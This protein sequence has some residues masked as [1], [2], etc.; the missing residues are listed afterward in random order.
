MLGMS[1]KLAKKKVAQPIRTTTLHGAVLPQTHLAGSHLV[2]KCPLRGQHLR[3]LIMT[4]HKRPNLKIIDLADSSESSD[5]MDLEPEWASAKVRVALAGPSAKAPL[6]ENASAL[7][8][9]V[10][11]HS[12]VV[13]DLTSPKKPPRCHRQCLPTAQLTPTRSPSAQLYAACF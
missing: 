13:L 9:S 6:K 8:N 12:R 5:G 7:T 10:P 11:H 4:C 1:I 3:R 2:M